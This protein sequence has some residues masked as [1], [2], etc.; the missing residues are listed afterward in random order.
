PRAHP[1]P[2]PNLHS[3]PTRRSSDLELRVAHSRYISTM[4][5]TN[6]SSCQPGVRSSTISRPDS[7]SRT[8]SISTP[9]VITGNSSFFGEGEAA[10]RQKIGS[11]GDRHL[12]RGAITVLPT[13]SGPV[14]S[15]ADG[16]R[17]SSYADGAAERPRYFAAALRTAAASALCEDP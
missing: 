11:T 7:P 3:F 8:P 9:S 4:P 15:R 16:E 1:P 10:R 2:H 5:G 13:G 14:K 12:G 6:L 17:L